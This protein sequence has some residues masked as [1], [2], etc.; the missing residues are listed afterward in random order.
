[1]AAR[2]ILTL[3]LSRRKGLVASTP[4]F[5]TVRNPIRMMEVEHVAAG[6]EMAEIRML[7]G[8]Y[9]P[10]MDACATYRVLFQELEAFE[11]DL[12]IHVHLKNNVLFP[13]AIAL[14]AVPATPIAAASAC[15]LPEHP[16][17]V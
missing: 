17:A 4:P 9:T 11:Q 10:P 6:D 2:S 7:T 15:V 8:D 5:G 16:A 3:A 13:K 1:L 14:E 12:H